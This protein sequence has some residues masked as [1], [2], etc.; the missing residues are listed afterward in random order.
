MRGLK[1]KPITVQKA[2]NNTFSNA[3]DVVFM[4]CNCWNGIICTV[5]V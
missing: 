4:I 5:T 3:F 2:E 1:I